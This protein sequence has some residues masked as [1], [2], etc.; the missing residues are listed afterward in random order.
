MEQ[1]T[2][3]PLD[4]LRKAAS[5]V[6]EL[7]DYGAKFAKWWAKAESMMHAMNNRNHVLSADGVGVNTTRDRARK[8]CEALQKDYEVY[9]GSVSG[10]NCPLVQSDPKPISIRWMH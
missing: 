2:T 8:S 4:L 9:R 10:C 5:N 3:V 7:V 1:D 6:G